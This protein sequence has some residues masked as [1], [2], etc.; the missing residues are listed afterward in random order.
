MVA[1]WRHHLRW[2]PDAGN[3]LVRICGGGAQQWAYLLRPI[4]GD[5]TDA[6]PSRDELADIG[7]VRDAV[8]IAPGVCGSIAPAGFDQCGKLC[9]KHAACKRLIALAQNALAGY[10]L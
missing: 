3:P 7:H 6:A 4:S 5:P 1:T 9:L 10:G 2:E 8:E